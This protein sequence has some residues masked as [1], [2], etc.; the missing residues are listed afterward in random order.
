MGRLELFL[1]EISRREPLYFQYRAREDKDPGWGGDGYKDH[2][3]QS[4][5][6]LAPED[7]EGRRQV[8]QSYLEG[9]FWV[10]QYYHEG[11]RSWGWF[12]PFHY[13]PLASDLVDL[14]RCVLQT[15]TGQT[16]KDCGATLAHSHRPVFPPL[17][18]QHE[19]HLHQGAALHAPH[20]APQRA[21]LPERALPPRAL[22]RPHGAFMCTLAGESF[23]LSLVPAGL[24]HQPPCQTSR[25]DTQVRE[26]SPLREFYPPDFETDRNGKQNT[27]CVSTTTAGWPY[28]LPLA[29]NPY[30][31]RHIPTPQLLGRAWC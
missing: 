15:R 26:D 22:P 17:A 23:V 31:P 1:R 10:L 13:G 16:A 3:Y 7:A 30:T 19:H 4:K 18:G 9:L 5:L 21:A 27:W 6:G 14:P 12:F 29:E 2:Y 28:S 24:T 11:V 8:A 25:G 20:A